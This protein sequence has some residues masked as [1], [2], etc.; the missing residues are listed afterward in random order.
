MN[1]TTDLER[2]TATLA[3]EAR[4]LVISDQQTYEL[5]AERLRGVVGL[6]AEIIEHHR[7]MKQRSHQAW[8]AVIAAEKKLLDPVAEAERA[9]KYNIGAYEFEQRRLEEETRARAEAEANA[10]AMA[11]REREIELAEAAG[12]DAHEVAA[13]CAEP[14]PLVVQEQPPPTFR[15]AAGV[16]TAH[17]WKGE[18]VSLAQLLKAIVRGE[19]SPTLVAADQSAINALAR[20][21][22]GTLAIPGIRFYDETKVRARR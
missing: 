11:D 7:E 21:T 8:Q 5:A 14:L 15:R 18:C 16:S 1:E 10:R 4:S 2:R 17:N 22:R 13:I 3:D 20:A 12:A 19:A 9:Y 6:R